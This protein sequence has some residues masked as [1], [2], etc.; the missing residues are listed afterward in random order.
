MSKRRMRM[1]RTY[2]VMI[3]VAAL[4]KTDIAADVVLTADAKWVKLSPRV[5]VV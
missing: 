1:T 5:V 4:R 2:Q 3:P